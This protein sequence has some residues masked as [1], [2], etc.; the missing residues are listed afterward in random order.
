MKLH[1]VLRYVPTC[2]FIIL[3]KKLDNLE[4]GLSIILLKK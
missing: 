3:L 2:L 1:H 4:R